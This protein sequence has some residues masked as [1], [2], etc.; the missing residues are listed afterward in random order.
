M[1]ENLVSGI[2]AIA[3]DVDLVQDFGLLTTPQ[4]HH[5]VYFHNRDETELAT[6]SGYYDQTISS[7]CQLLQKHGARQDGKL[8]VDCANGVGGYKV[9]ALVEA[10][11]KQG[12]SQDF[13]VL[14]LRNEGIGDSSAFLNE[15]VGAEWV[16]KGQ[17]IPGGVDPQV[18]TGIRCA[19]ID[20]DADRCV[21]FC[22]EDGVFSLFDGDRIAVLI[23]IFVREQLLQVQLQD[24]V[25]IAVIQ[26]AYANGASTMYIR[27]TLNIPAPLVKTGVS[28]HQ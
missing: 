8:I 11:H 26:T 14:D 5:I 28:I 1:I 10:A 6:E 18:D 16:Q 17:Q 22:I 3:Q 2:R 23:A 27:Q 13:A 24:G 25:T 7:F 19:S 15:G 21:F 4:L 20:G 12:K 9:R